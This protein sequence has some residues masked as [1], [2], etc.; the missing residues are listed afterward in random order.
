MT[1]IPLRRREKY[2]EATVE[3]IS[4]FA[5]ELCSKKETRDCLLVRSF[6]EFFDLKRTSPDDAAYWFIECWL[7]HFR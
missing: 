2:V 3:S 4:I 5:A 1:W 6:K 7:L